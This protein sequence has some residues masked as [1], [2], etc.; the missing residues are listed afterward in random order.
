MFKVKSQTVGSALQ[1]EF[2]L[3]QCKYTATEISYR[4]C[5]EKVCEI[6]ELQ[7]IFWGQHFWNKV[8]AKETEYLNPEVFNGQ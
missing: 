6:K 3:L 2:K 5:L 8:T 1:G 4:I 7:Y